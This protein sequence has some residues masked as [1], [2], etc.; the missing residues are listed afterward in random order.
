[1]ARVG[2]AAAFVDGEVV[3]GDVEIDAGRISAVG[4]TPAGASG[5]AVPGLVD[6]QVNGYAGVDFTTGDLDGYRSASAALA[7]VGVTS[8]LATLPTAPPERYEPALAVAAEAVRAGAGLGGGAP[9]VVGARVLGVHLEGPFLSP[10]RAGA[11]P[12][13]HLRA[14]DRDLLDGWLAS[15][16]VRLVTLAPEQPGALD[17]VDTLVA[18]GVTVAVGHSDADGATAHAAF[19]RGARAHTHVWNASR[20]VTARDPGTVGVA[21][22]RPDVVPCLIADRVHVSDEVLAFTLAATADRYVV[23]SDAVAPAGTDA[24]VELPGGGVRRADGTLAGG[25]GSLADSLRNLVALG[26]PL[27]E[28]IAA[29]TARPAALIGAPDAGHLRV[30]APADVA[31]LADDLEVVRVLVAGVEVGA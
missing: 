28:A 24:V 31:V 19:D 18:A 21:L 25:A 7:R 6:L 2:V 3:A 8:F 20:P 23:V 30:G 27:P 15:A 16:P 11:H 1:M 10:A 12:V 13:E 4:V 29:V 9:G 22:S 17:L 26:R 5:L 14:P